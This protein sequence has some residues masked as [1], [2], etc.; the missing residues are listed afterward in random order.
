LIFGD[1][2]DAISDDLADVEEILFRSEEDD[3][4]DASDEDN[5]ACCCCLGRRML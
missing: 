5:D 4:E 1:E 3:E 2:L